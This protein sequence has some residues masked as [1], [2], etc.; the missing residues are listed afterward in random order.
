MELILTLFIIAISIIPI[1][2]ENKISNGT[3]LRPFEFS[4]KY[5]SSSPQLSEMSNERAIVLLFLAWTIPQII[6]FAINLYQIEVDYEYDYEFFRPIY[7]IVGGIANLI[8]LWVCFSVRLN[9]WRGLIILLVVF[10][11]FIYI[12]WNF[13]NN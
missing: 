3:G 4:R 7:K 6:F 8:L 1:F 9:K 13:L 5:G 11:V 12:Y 2:V 10:Q